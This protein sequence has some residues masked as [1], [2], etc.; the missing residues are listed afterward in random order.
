MVGRCEYCHKVS[1]HD[2]RCPNYVLPKP[3]KCCSYCENGIYHDDKYIEN[4]N[5]EYIHEECA[6]DIEWL[7]YW[8]GYAIR[9]EK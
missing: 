9:K 8:L 4:D 1:D 3:N 6:S 5:G 7:L 2:C